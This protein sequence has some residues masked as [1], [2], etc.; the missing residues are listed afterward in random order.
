M[1]EAAHDGGA[2]GDGF[3]GGASSG[4]GVRDGFVH[5]TFAGA[6]RHDVSTT[7]YRRVW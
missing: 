3:L 1:G 4:G 7:T 6:V 5:V 2:E